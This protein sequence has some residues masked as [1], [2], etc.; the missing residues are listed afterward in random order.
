LIYGGAFVTFPFIIRQ[1]FQTEPTFR[2]Y[3][4]AATVA[5]VC[6]SLFVFDLLSLRITVTDETITIKKFFRKRTMNISDIHYVRKTWDESF[7]VVFHNGRGLTLLPTISG[8]NWFLDF[9][10]AHGVRIK[11]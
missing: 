7:R 9:L 5:S 10:K 11:S 6:L 3:S 8:L 4:L 2:D 1:A